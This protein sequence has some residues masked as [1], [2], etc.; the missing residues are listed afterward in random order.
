MQTVLFL[1]A[2]AALAYVLAHLVVE[3]LQD[4]PALLER[5][6][7]VETHGV[8][9]LEDVAVVAVLRRASVLIH[10]ALDL[11]EARDDALLARRAP[12]RLLGLGEVGQRV[13]EFVEVDVSHSGPLS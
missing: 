12:G 9:P 3:R 13:G 10:E 2:L 11:L 6:Q 5:T 7:P 8:E 1:I 4:R